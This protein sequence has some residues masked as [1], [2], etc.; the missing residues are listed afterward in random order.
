M[1]V[2]REILLHLSPDDQ[3]LF[4]R[5]LAVWARNIRN[6]PRSRSSDIRAA[7]FEAREKCE[8]SFD[9]WQQVLVSN[10]EF[11]TRLLREVVG[12]SAAVQGMIQAGCK[13]L[14]QMIWHYHFTRRFGSKVALALMNKVSDMLAEPPA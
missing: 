14:E 11:T 1:D 7:S 12:Y 10:P 3:D 5:L 6:I 9:Q 4:P 13:G 2:V 8:E